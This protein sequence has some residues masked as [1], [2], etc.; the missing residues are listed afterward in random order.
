[1][2]LF[3]KEQVMEITIYASRLVIGDVASLAL[4]FKPFPLD[5]PRQFGNG[6]VIVVSPNDR[7][8][9]VVPENATIDDD[10]MLLSWQLGATRRDSTA[11]EVNALANLELH[12]FRLVSSQGQEYTA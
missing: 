7:W 8:R 6:V 4:S 1:L 2:A 9:V 10:E 5:S 11:N 12:G 3:S